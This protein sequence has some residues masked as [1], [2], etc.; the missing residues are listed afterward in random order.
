MRLLPALF[1]VLACLGALSA[2][3]SAHALDPFDIEVAAKAGY[4][5]SPLS[6]NGGSSTGNPLGFGLGGR[7]GLVLDD[8]IYFGGSVTYFFTGNENLTNAAVSGSSVA[9]TPVSVSTK[10]LMYGA[11]M[12]YGSDLFSLLTLRPH[13]GFGDATISYSGESSSTTTWYLQPGMTGLVTLGKFLVGADVDML[14]LAVSQP[15]AAF[16][17]DAQVGAKF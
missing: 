12:G 15:Q 8:T 13:I 10:V 9:E 7:A 4:A 6:G 2:D 17:F 16:L 5:T 1:A 3:R 14:L 11:E